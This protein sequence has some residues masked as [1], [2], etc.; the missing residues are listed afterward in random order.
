M[1][2]ERIRAFS[3]IHAWQLAGVSLMPVVYNPGKQPYAN[4]PCNNAKHYRHAHN[5]QGLPNMK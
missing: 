3:H 4:E 5:S 2:V 1:I